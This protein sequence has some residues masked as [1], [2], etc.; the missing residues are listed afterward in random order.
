MHLSL[1][2]FLAKMPDTR[3]PKSDFSLCWLFCLVSLHFT[4]QLIKTV[5]FVI[6]HASARA[7]VSENE[8]G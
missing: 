7:G 5:V 1:L 6:I 3:K 2:F 4:H 8:R